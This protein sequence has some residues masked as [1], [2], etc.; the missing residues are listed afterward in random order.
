[1]IFALSACQQSDATPTQIVAA[2]DAQVNISTPTIE[3]FPFKTSEPG[4]TSIHGILLVLDPMT[5][6][7]ASDDAIYLVPLPDAGISTIPHFE[8]GTVPQ[9]EVDETSGEFMFT[10][11]QPGSYAVVVITKSVAQIPARFYQTGNYAIINVEASQ[12]DTT[13]ELDK[14]SLP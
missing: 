6:I 10:N 7:P 12:A 5:L 1:M 3:P 4:T 8:K 11:I 9:A 14:L 13:I 2:T